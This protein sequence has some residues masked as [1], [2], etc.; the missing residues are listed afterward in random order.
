MA[1]RGSI[2]LEHAFPRKQRETK[3]IL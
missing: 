3:F 2:A 1:E